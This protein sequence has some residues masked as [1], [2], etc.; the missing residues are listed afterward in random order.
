MKQGSGRR[1]G[2]KG[3]GWGRIGKRD[4]CLMRGE[5]RGKGKC[6]F[7]ALRGDGRAYIYSMGRRQK[8]S[9]NSLHPLKINIHT[10]M[11]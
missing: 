4:T 6:C 8:K 10:I 3:K 9:E 2:G 7:P 1:T 5:G 11:H